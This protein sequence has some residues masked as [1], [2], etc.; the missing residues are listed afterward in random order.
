M[1]LYVL[2]ERHHWPS[3]FV[4]LLRNAAHEPTNVLLELQAG[5]SQTGDISGGSESPGFLRANMRMPRSG[6]EFDDG[7]LPA[8]LWKNPTSKQLSVLVIPCWHC[9]KRKW[10]LHGAWRLQTSLPTVS[11]AG[12]FG[13]L[14]SR[15]MFEIII[16][17]ISS[18]V[19]VKRS[20]FEWYRPC[21]RR[22]RC[23]RR[24][25]VS[26]ICFA[27][28]QYWELP[29]RNRMGEWTSWIARCA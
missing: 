24:N 22:S 29:W 25:H 28:R 27:A 12:I 16:H 9:F 7:V 1:D 13:Y 5:G 15:S 18:S 19:V 8:W 4:Y 26:G 3:L 10:R 2:F 21:L 20:S 6:N 17:R 23:G 14:E 11:F